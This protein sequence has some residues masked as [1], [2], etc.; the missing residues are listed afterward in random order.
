MSL[1]RLYVSE[2]ALL[3]CERCS[4]VGDRDSF[5]SISA[6][7]CSYKSQLKLLQNYFK[8]LLVNSNTKIL[9]LALLSATL[10]VKNNNL[11]LDKPCHKT[12]K[13]CG[14]NNI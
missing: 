8:N 11:T 12:V 10:R 14:N 2:K 6:F 9:Q 1:I 3:H 5:F 7:L 4:E 13:A